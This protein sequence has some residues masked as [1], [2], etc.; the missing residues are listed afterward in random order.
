MSQDQRDTSGV[1]I[2]GIDMSI[3]DMAWFLFK[4]MIAGVLVA[5]P[6]GIFLYLLSSL[7]RGSYLFERF[8]G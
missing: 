3:M 1:T 8:M 7:I 4:W 5:I 6:T 2:T